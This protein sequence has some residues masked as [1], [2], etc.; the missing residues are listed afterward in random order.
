MSKGF[1]S[2]LSKITV[3]TIML[4]MKRHTY[5]SVA[6]VSWIVMIVLSVLFVVPQTQQIISES[7][8]I[9]LQ[10]QKL[11][12]ATTKVAFLQSL[13]AQDLQSQKTLL[14]TVLPSQKPVTPLISSMEQLAQ[15]A[16]VT[17]KNFELNPGSVAT[18]SA[19]STT[20]ITKGFVPGVA[21]LQLKL[22]LQGGFA[23]MNIDRKSTRLNSSHQIISYAVFCLKKK[24][25]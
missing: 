22:E 9:S 3:A 6:V 15:D 4:Y 12:D 19:A 17:L 21:S 10:Q 5:L 14:Q 20:S 16:G 24:K 13:S 18:N 2:P 7:T 25:V 23:Q 1:Q 11:A 8:Q